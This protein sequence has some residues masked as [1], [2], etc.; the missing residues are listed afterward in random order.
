MGVICACGI[1]LTVCIWGIILS[2]KDNKA[3]RKHTRGK[4][5]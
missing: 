3:E 2:Y 4:E 1:V 5:N